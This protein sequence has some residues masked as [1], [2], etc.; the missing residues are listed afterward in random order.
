M[1]HPDGTIAGHRAGCHRR[2]GPPA[3]QRTPAARNTPCDLP[4]RAPDRAPVFPVHAVPEGHAPDHRHHAS[5]V[6]VTGAGIPRG[7][8]SAAKD[9]PCR[10]G[11]AKS[12]SRPRNA[13]PG[14]P[15]PRRDQSQPPVRRPILHRWS[16]VPD[17]PRHARR[18]PECAEPIAPAARPRTPPC[19]PQDTPSGPIA[20]PQ[21]TGALSGD[22]VLAASRPAN[23]PPSPPRHRHPGRSFPFSARPARGHSP[24]LC[25]IRHLN[26][27]QPRARDRDP[28]DH[29]LFPQNTAAP[30]SSCRKYSSPAF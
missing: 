19:L 3:P 17:D 20:A 8:G 5:V 21:P 9:R 12:T 22:P 6:S 2:P 16:S 1:N 15:T 18:I 10:P 27:G 4:R 7:C 25:P 13:G 14:T 26:R 29:A 28:K 11:I 24:R 30:T 23:R